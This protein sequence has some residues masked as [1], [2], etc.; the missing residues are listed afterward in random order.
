[1]SEDRPLTEF[2]AAEAE[3][4]D[5][6]SDAEAMT[7]Q[8]AQSATTDTNTRFEVDD[9]SNSDAVEPVTITSRWQP[10]G[11]ACARCDAT[12]KRQWRDGD[13]FVCSGCKEW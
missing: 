5:S 3:P 11:A 13:A 1:M 12:T 10:E 9:A 8:T 6:E 2:T 4:D 7:E